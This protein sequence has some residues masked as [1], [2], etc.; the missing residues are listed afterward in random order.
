MIMKII[1]TKNKPIKA[2]KMKFT[3]QTQDYLDYY[4][5][6]WDDVFTQVTYQF[7]TIPCNQIP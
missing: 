4:N 6:Y 3:D 5:K 2:G 7:D 1:T